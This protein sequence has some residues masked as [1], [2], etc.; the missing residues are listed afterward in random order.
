M[1]NLEDQEDVPEGPQRPITKGASKPSTPRNR[2]GAVKA[3]FLGVGTTAVITTGWVFAG[4]WAV[5]AVLFVV[6][7]VALFH[8]LGEAVHLG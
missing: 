5:A 6:L 8:C 3:F 7:V 4:W 2:V 1:T